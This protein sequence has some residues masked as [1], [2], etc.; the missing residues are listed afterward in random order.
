MRGVYDQGKV[1]DIF[2]DLFGGSFWMFVG[3]SR[4]F[5]RV[6]SCS[7]WFFFHH[8]PP[9]FTLPTPPLCWF[10]V[11]FL[12]LFGCCASV[13]SSIPRHSRTRN[14][15]NAMITR[16]YYFSL[17]SMYPC[18]GCLCLQTVYTLP[19]FLR[20]VMTIKSKCFSY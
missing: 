10:F 17:L 7:F 14:T 20:Y 4:V 13:T 11:L 8:P 9:F 5:R 3:I 12:S 15:E 1:L 2:G 16:T 19:L 18:I 6:L